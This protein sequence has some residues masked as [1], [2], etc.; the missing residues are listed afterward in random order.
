MNCET[1]AQETA[2]AFNQLFQIGSVYGA[3]ILFFGLLLGFVIGFCCRC[4]PHPCNE[5]D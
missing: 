3:G 1:F 4:C 5:P 2:E